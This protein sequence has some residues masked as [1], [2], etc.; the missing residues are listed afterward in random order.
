LPCIH[1]PFK[2]LA[3]NAHISSLKKSFNKTF[4]LRYSVKMASQ[5]LGGGT[6]VLDK[7]IELRDR[8][9]TKWVETTKRE[10]MWK[11]GLLERLKEIRTGGGG[12]AGQIF[13]GFGL[14]GSPKAQ[15]TQYSPSSPPTS[16]PPRT[17]TPPSQTTPVKTYTAPIKTF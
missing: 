12:G 1:F 5:I 4:I 6:P 8:A 15:K 17:Y 2:K 10:P 3:K 14:L 11:I 13:G 9:S 7:A 16:S